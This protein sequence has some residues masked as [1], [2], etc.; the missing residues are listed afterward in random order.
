MRRLIAAITVLTDRMAV[1]D[2]LEMID[3]DQSDGTAAEAA[4][5]EV[6]AQSLNAP[7]PEDSRHEYLRGTGLSLHRLTEE[8]PQSTSTTESPRP[9]AEAA[10]VEC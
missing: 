8:I 5:E 2:G 1:V 9:R 7:T 4:T 10:A 6:G 3:F